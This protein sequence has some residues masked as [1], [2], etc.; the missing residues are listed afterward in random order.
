MGDWMCTEPGCGGTR[1]DAVRFVASCRE[2]PGAGKT[3]PDWDAH[4]HR[5][6]ISNAGAV[7][8]FAA[9]APVDVNEGHASWYEFTYAEE[10]GFLID[11][12][13]S[14]TLKDL[15]RDAY[16][17]GDAFRREFGPVG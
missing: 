6:G 11:D 9:P 10:R 3:G 5:P 8:R 13:G 7:L 16:S 15:M 2:V 12:A 14:E 17:Q 4:E 1:K